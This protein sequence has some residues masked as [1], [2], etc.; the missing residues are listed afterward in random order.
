MRVGPAGFIGMAEG[1]AA[2][3][4][5]GL[6][7]ASL[8][9]LPALP[10]QAARPGLPVARDAAAIHLSGPAVGRAA[11]MPRQS[12]AITAPRMLYYGGP[13]I[14]TPRVVAVIWGGAVAPTTVASAGPFLRALLNSTY[15]D[16]LAQYNTRLTGVN[17][18]VGTQQ[19]IGRGKLRART[20]FNPANKSTALTDAAIQT[21]LRA[22]IAAKRLPAPDLNTIYIVY[23]P[24]G[25]SITAFGRQSCS[26]FGGYH[27]AMQSTVSASNIFY[28]V[29]PDCGQGWNA[30]TAVTAHELAEAVTDPI[31]TPGSNPLYPQAWNTVDGSEI[32]DLCERQNGI[33]NIT[34]SVPGQTTPSYV[35]QQYWSNTKGACTTTPYYSSP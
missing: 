16:P 14:S 23:F 21:E 28:A 22:Q 1:V 24:P 31:P 27:A 34:P 25:I 9:L 19:A 33:L 35:V 15:M 18:K 2:A 4:L 11:A 17:G 29:I 26:F 7:A 3:A 12:A 6:L 20:Q 30:I 13:V 32:G 10:A 8:A 5:R